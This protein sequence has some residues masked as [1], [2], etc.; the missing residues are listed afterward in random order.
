[1]PNII[2]F[3]TY[4]FITAITPGPNNIMSLSNAVRFG[5][6]KSLPFNFGILVGFAIVMILCTLFSSALYAF[7]PSIKPAMLG[8]GALYMLHLAYKTW[9]SSGE[10]EWKESKNNRFLSGMVLQFMNPKIMIYGITAMSSFILPYYSDLLH[11]AVFV[12][13]LTLTG[14]FCTLFWSAFGSLFTKVYTHH[15]KII[16]PILALLLVYCGVALFF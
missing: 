10:I 5:F 4:I 13:V 14:F 12:I 11:L 1:M 15:A 3:A 16:N 6:R 2:Q 7:I 9:K 8:I